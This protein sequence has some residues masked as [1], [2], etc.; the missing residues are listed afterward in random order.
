MPTEYKSTFVECERLE[1][2][3]LEDAKKHAA[4]EEQRIARMKSASK[5]EV[6][7]VLTMSEEKRTLVETLLKEDYV[8]VSSDDDDGPEED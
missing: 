3:R 1:A 4:R 5:R 8:M 2:K 6:V 7:Q